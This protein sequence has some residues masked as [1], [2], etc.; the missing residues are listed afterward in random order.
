[1][2]GQS[3]EGAHQEVLQRLL[4]AEG[5][6]GERVQK[7][8]EKAEEIVKSARKEADR[9]VKDA[10]ESARSEAEEIIN[11]AEEQA[12]KAA[13]M[14]TAGIGDIDTLRRHADENMSTAVDFLVDVIINREE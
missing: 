1:M 11:E 10:E 3:S 9:Q 4:E 14:A 8:K 5:E 2:T 6:A 7:G 12:G 13:G